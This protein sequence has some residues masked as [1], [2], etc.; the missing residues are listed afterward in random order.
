MWMWLW[1]SLI[2]MF[3]GNNLKHLNC[4]LSEG[5]LHLYFRRKCWGPCLCLCPVSD[6]FCSWPVKNGLLPVHKVFA[7]SACMVV[8][9]KRCGVFFF[10]SPVEEVIISPYIWGSI[11]FIQVSFSG[12]S[13][14]K[15]EKSP[16]GC[17]RSCAEPWGTKEL[18]CIPRFSHLWILICEH[19]PVDDSS[20]FQQWSISRAWKAGFCHCSLDLL[21]KDSN[22]PWIYY[23]AFC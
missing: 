12:S 15:K 13:K 6:T 7:A 21:W 17:S 10:P 2:G 20:V 8:K 14:K 19:R 3:A 1:M 9:G 16:A 5:Q 18:E 4:D 11:A 23:R 22:L